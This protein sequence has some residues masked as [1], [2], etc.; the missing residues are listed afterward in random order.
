MELMSR[1]KIVNY[2]RMREIAE[3]AVSRINFSIDLDERVENLSVADKQLIAISRALL[4]DARLIIMDEPTT[5]LTRKEVKSLFSVIRNLQDQGISILFVSHKLDEIFEIA[6]S[7]TILRNGENVAAGLTADLDEKKFAY[8][9]TG[10][11][12]A[13]AASVPSSVSETPV[14]S[15]RNL[16]AEGTFHDVSFDLHAGEILGITGL[17]GSGRTEVVESIFGLTKR[18]GGSIE[19]DGKRAEIGNVKDAMKYGIGYVAEDRLTEGLFLSQSITL[20]VVVSRL[21]AVSSRN[22]FLKWDQIN[23]EVRRWIMELSIAAS[24]PEQPVQTLSGG[25]QQKIVLARW[26]A[27]DLSVLILNGPTV[28]VDIGSKYDI[29]SLLRNLADK[30]LAIIVISDD[31]PEIINLSRRILVMREGRVIEELDPDKTTEAR[32]GEL[33]TGVA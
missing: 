1:H 8:H 29:H 2:R 20:N 12:F 11:E 4:Y 32:L 24:D 3:T 23:R 33:I 30:G 5:A 17:L 25:N 9:M 28:G 21:E 16:E 27:N 19:I 7:Y 26:L 31:L 18:D 10:R 14:L 13:E 6:E 22:G 15:V